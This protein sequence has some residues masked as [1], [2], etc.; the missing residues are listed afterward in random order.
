[1]AIDIKVDRSKQ[2]TIFTGTGELSF[3]EITKNIAS[4]YDS[5]PTLNALLDVNHASMNTISLSQIEQIAELLQRL[6]IAR[7]GGRTAIVAAT[8]LNFGLARMLEA[9]AS[10]PDQNPFDETRVF[11]N[12]KDASSWLAKE[13]NSDR[14]N[15]L[16]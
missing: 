15:K 3:D 7:K 11:R 5:S 12:I 14:N 9:M 10:G 4:F 8:D 1:M 6:R 2:L 13:E 16:D